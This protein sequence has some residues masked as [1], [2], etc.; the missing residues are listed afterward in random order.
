MLARPRTLP[1]R[2]IQ[3]CLPSGSAVPCWSKRGASSSG[4]L[5]ARQGG[6]G[7]Q[8]FR[9]TANRCKHSSRDCFA[10][11]RGCIILTMG[12]DPIGHANRDLF[13]PAATVVSLEQKRR[14]VLPKDLPNAIKH[15]DDQDLDRLL[16]VAVAEAKRRGRLPSTNQTTEQ[17]SSPM[18]RSPRGRRVQADTVSL[19]R[20]QIN[21]VRAASKAGVKPSLI[22]RQF[23][24]SQSDIRKVLAMDAAERGSVD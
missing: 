20:G 16:A 10:C 12:R 3:P 5:A 4:S 1:A 13:S 15:L 19:T 18:R 8:S 2:F 7:F 21:A 9:V 11:P 17:S 23:G 6:S 22:A 14:H 24:L